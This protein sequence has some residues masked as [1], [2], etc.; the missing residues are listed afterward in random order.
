LTPSIRSASAGLALACALFAAP[1]RAEGESFD[2]KVFLDW[3]ARGGVETCITREQ[4]I[5]DVEAIVGRPMFAPRNEADRVLRVEVDG[6]P[7]AKLTGQILLVT[8]GGASLGARELSLESED[9]KD[10]ASALALALSIMADLP[11]TPA[12]RSAEPKKIPA[13]PP[14]PPPPRP[15]LA[16][17]PRWH[18]VVGLGPMGSLDSNGDVTAGGQATVVVAPPRFL[19]FSV[20][21]LSAP[22]SSSTPAGM[23]YTLLS[24]T[25]A[26]TLCT[27]AWSRGRF[28]SLAC[29][30]PDLTVH[31]GWGAGFTQSHT[32]L[33]STVGAL[34]HSYAA[35][36][37]AHGWRVVVG[38]AATASPQRVSLGFT[39]AQNGPTT[40]YR[41]PIV[42]AFAT[43]GVA[44]DLF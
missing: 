34:L 23:S 2:G 33:S 8:A 38:L 29:F 19:P 35:Y 17:P 6:L 40:F 41:T 24:T 1:A 5:V 7:P 15:P 16:P 9:C 4:V 12:E 10:V 36:S 22:R 26:A 11:R 43:I 3:T 31:A 20:A 25:V 44:A 42:S 18:A 39:D 14:S 30:G 28:A 37:V 27:P 21:V 32:G 13:P